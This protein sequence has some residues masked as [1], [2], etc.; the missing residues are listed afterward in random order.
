MKQQ[1]LW[2]FFFI[3]ILHYGG[4]VLLLIQCNNNIIF[5]DFFVPFYKTPVINHGDIITMHDNCENELFELL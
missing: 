5:L 3:Y 2:L 1:Y 4:M